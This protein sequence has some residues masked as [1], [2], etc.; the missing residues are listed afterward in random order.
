MN[1]VKAQDLAKELSIPELQQYANGSNPEIMPPY[2]AL[3]ALQAKESMQKKMAAMQGAAQG[4]QPSVKEQVEQKAG[5]MALQGQ[6]QQQ[7]Q[8]Q[9]TQQMQHR[10]MPTTENVPQPE[11][12]PQVEPMG[13]ARGGLTRLPVNFNFRQGGIIGYAGPEGSLVGKKPLDEDAQIALQEAQRT[14]DR[15]AMMLT[16][17]KLAAAGY[18]VATLIP[19]GVMGATESV[20]RG[21]A[22]SRLGRAFGLDAIPKLPESAY[23]GDRTSMT[24]MMDRVNREEEAGQNPAEPQMPQSAP[25]AGPQA[26]PPTGL[27]AAMPQPQAMPK[28]QMQPQAGPQGMPQVK[29]PAAPQMPFAPQAPIAPEAPVVSDQDKLI[30]EEIARRK[31]F[32]VEGEAGAGAESR[33]ADRRKRFEETRPTGLDD[34]IRVFGQAG[35]YKGLSGMGPAYTANEDSKRAARSKFEAEMETQQSGIEDKRRTEGVGRAAGIGTGLAGLRE[36]Q[37]KEKESTSRNVTLL[38]Q[39]RIQAAAQNRPGEVERLLARYTELKLKDP[40][41]AEEMMKNIMQIKTG[42]P[43]GKGTMTRDQA[44][45]NVGKLLTDPVLQSRMQK[46]AAAALGKKDI[47]VSEM[48]EYFVQKAMGGGSSGIGGTD[49]T[50]PTAGTRLKFDAQG[51]Q[52]K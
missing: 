35:Q 50:K 34:L 7:A 23:G 30:A 24:P 29:P 26:A 46:E 19:R 21:V 43:G 42:L 36:M 13:M 25:M 15:E 39:Y 5:L 6:Q 22:D 1:L 16:I 2:V 10:P 47:T 33:M 17:R 12:Q 27:P 49:T 45:D 18:D 28:P 8:Q 52:I 3:G 4:E 44:I 48:Q 37:Q 32:G 41:A 51:N 20:V 31:A 11:P 9:M 14:G 40:A 38:E